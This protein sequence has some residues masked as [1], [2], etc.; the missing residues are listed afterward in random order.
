MSATPEAIGAKY[1]RAGQQVRAQ[2]IDVT[3]KGTTMT[4]EYIVEGRYLAATAT[5]AGERPT[6]EVTGVQVGGVEIWHWLQDSYVGE[7]IVQAV[8]RQVLT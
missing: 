4:C 7:E 1:R 3:F 6:V 8:E 5:D 2:R